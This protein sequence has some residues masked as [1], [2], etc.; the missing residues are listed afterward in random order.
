MPL[1][2]IE[3]A[4]EAARDRP[5]TAGVECLAQHRMGHEPHDSP[6]T[7]GE[8]MNPRE[9]MMP[10]G[11][12]K[13]R[14]RLSEVRVGL[15]EAFHETRNRAGADGYVA[16]DLDVSRTVFAGYDRHLLAGA[17]DGEPTQIVRQ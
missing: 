14:V 7:V 3:I 12:R 13:N 11:S 8:R 10:C 16:A 1:V 17:F 6:I 4:G 5:H 2:L 9:A 15:L